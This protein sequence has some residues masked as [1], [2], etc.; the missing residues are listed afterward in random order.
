MLKY[1][2]MWKYQDAELE[3]R[4]LEFKEFRDQFLQPPPPPEFREKNLNFANEDSGEKANE[5]ESTD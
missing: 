1:D 4:Y 5:S 3:K 2:Q